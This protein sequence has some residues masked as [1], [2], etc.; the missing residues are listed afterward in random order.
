MKKYAFV[1][2]MLASGCSNPEQA[3]VTESNH[4]QLKAYFSK[5]AK[6]LQQLN[7]EIKKTVVVNGKS[8]T[9]SLKIASWEKEFSAFIDADINKKAWAGAFQKRVNNTSE[10]YTSNNEKV[11]VKSVL[12]QKA[13]DKVT[14]V[15]IL[16]TNKNYLYTSSDTLSYYPGK[17]YEVRKRQQIRL[18][19]EKKYRIT[20]IF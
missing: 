15:V 10:V 11:P 20:G 19:D 7:P 9:K 12:I 1:F 8:E 16:V 14:G 13:N 4:F 5:E 3:A 18:L 2:L 17:Q 6:R